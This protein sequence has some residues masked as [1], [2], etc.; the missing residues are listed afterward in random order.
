MSFGDRLSPLIFG[1]QT[2]PSFR[3]DSDMSVSFAWCSPV[4][5]MQVGWIWV[6]QGFAKKAP[7]LYAR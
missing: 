7:F 6:K 4:T 2:L 1:T 5:G 3:S